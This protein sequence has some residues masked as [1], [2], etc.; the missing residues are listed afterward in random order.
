MVLGFLVLCGCK[1]K[2]PAREVG[3]RVFV[4][5]CFQ[6]RAPAPFEAHS[7]GNSLVFSWADASRS[8]S[9]QVQVLEP[10]GLTLPALVK[11]A[12]EVFR[13]RAEWRLVSEGPVMVGGEPGHRFVVQDPRERLGRIFVLHAGRSIVFA[14]RAAPERATALEAAL[15][16]LVESLHWVSCA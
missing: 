2:E 4:P 3:P 14:Y 1:S 11:R 13:I 15:Q 16:A 9:L 10:L 7:Q 12:T 6:Y 8:E 5:G